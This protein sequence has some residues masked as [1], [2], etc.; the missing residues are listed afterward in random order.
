MGT[1]PFWQ[2]KVPK[3]SRRNAFRG[4]GIADRSE[5]MGMSERMIVNRSGSAESLLKKG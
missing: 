2:R 1:K 4:F 5:K 3:E